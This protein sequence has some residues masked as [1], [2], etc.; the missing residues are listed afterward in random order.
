MP[1][2]ERDGTRRMN[3]I[4]LVTS[5]GGLDAL[6]GVLRML[7]EDLPAAVVI[8]Q[9]LGGQGSVLVSILSRRISLPVV[10]AQPNEPLKPG[11][12]T[13]C[14]PRSRLEVLPDLTCAVTARDGGLDERPLDALLQSLADS[15]GEAGVGVVLT[16]M[17]RDGAHGAKALHDAGGLV[18]A[19]SPD[20][21]EHAAMPQAAMDAGAV[22]LVLPLHEIGATL[23][24]AVLGRRLP[25]PAA[26]LQ[27][28]R[29]VFGTEG[30]TASMAAEIDWSRTPVGRV[31]GWSPVLRTGVSIVMAC[32][33][34]ANLWW[35]DDL[36]FFSNDA[37]LTV[38]GGRE[39]TAFAQPYRETFADVWDQ[40]A[41]AIERARRGKAARH[42]AV[43]FRYVRDGRL[44][45]MWTDL[46]DTP[47]KDQD[48]RVVGVIRVAHERTAEVLAARR[49]T[50]LNALGRKARAG[51]RR[52]ALGAA[53]QVL[54]EAADVPFAAAYLLDPSGQRAGLV[55]A[56]GLD[57]GG[58]LAP[59]ELHVTADGAWPVHAAVTSGHAVVVDDIAARFRGHLAGA[60]RVLARCAVVH[61]LRD[62]AEDRIT[63][64]LIVGADPYLAFDAPYRDFLAL[65]ADTVAARAAE[66]H[67]RQ[68]ERERL[69]RL[70][71]LDRT[72][73]EFFSNV[74]HEFRTPLT[75]ML[76]PL[77]AA[78]ERTDS[79]PARLV[80]ELEL[81]RRNAQ[82]LLRLTG[83]L[84]DFSQAEAGRLR[85]QPAAT[86][87]AARTGEIV[88]QFASAAERAGLALR[89]AIEPIGRPVWVD[90]E[91]WEKILANLLSNALK[92][93]L[94][95]S[96]EVELHARTKHAELVV[97]DTGVG[98]PEAE[99]PHIFKRFHRVHGVRG[100]TQ[101]GVGIGLALVDELVRRHHGRVRAASAVGSG[102]AI[103]VWIPFGRRPTGTTGDG[104]A[105]VEATTA[106]AAGLAEEAARW[107]GA[108]GGERAWAGDARADGSAGIHVPGARL[109]VV[110]DNQDMRDYLYRLLAG[111]WTVQL[112]R[113]GAEALDLARREPPDLVL[114]DVMMPGLDGFALLSALRDD[115]VLADVP[116]I[117]V[118]ARAGEEAG[119][120]GMLAGADDYIVKP[121]AARELVARI[122]AQLEL[123]LMRR[124]QGKLDAFRVALTDTLR[125]LPDPVEVQARA[126]ALL[127]RHLGASRAYYQE[128][129]RVAGTFTV[130]R[131]Y[132]DGLPS[133]AG[134]YSLADYN[135]ELVDESHRTGRPLVV[136][137][138]ADLDPKAA[139]AWA[140]LSVRAGV[141]APNMRSG[142]CVAALGITSAEPRDWTAEEIALVEE[143]AERTWAYVERARAEQE[144][145]HSEERFRTVADA[146][147]ALIWQNDADGRNVFVNRSFRDY[148]GLTDAGISGDRWQSLIHPDE[149]D[150][151]V[152]A[153]LRTVRERADWRRRNR[154]RRQDGSWR[155][156]DNYATP[157]FAVDGSYLGHVGVSVDVTD[158]R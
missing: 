121:F 138:A 19:Q 158:R 102:T 4:A 13:V 146:V 88:A 71:D 106:V 84:L 119:I 11:C 24:D 43:P 156:F 3:V 36:L 34:V 32:P 60:D 45:D 152:A 97:R 130:H 144:L 96:I 99:L 142:V 91:M 98:I 139:A 145:R 26:E 7:P 49:L 75:L 151:Y 148:T 40:V 104:P 29:D 150:D 131:N 76:G 27:A 33:D 129:D 153:Y 6:S 118:T 79:L 66:A 90:P 58:T 134:T 2:S 25:L 94:E 69:E 100:R 51:S 103:T 147:P 47:I 72:K 78:L 42:L 114:S 107:D 120:E 1:A 157:L 9:H 70:A 39:Q 28:I 85:A 59:R 53:V 113:N 125:S 87:L 56:K 74:S 83:A 101:E 73:T 133:L 132:T 112:A 10:W 111:D 5:A 93:T 154:L 140:A 149:A 124:R 80:S 41:P 57:E 86:D 52:E 123:T 108:D 109:L 22:D 95:G 38:L 31:T 155:T 141:A 20:T 136:P 37:A 50:T 117:L 67:A 128:F 122:G 30:V 21:A 16:G 63:G 92:Y 65:V 12:V 116:V 110:D 18:I 23:V 126:A 62:D 135:D 82:R 8:A 35:G 64:V 14:P 55:A 143:T 15:V 48:G 137:D 81:A 89:T 68:R 61:P 105:P 77:D 115:P 46:T 54:S 44:Q 127:G 17:L